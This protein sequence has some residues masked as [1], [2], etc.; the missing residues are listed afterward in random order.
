MIGDRIIIKEEHI[1]KAS[2]IL[3][4]ITSLVK[5]NRKKPIK[6]VIGIGGESG[7]GKTEINTVIQRLLWE[8]HKLRAKQIHLDDYYITNWQNR[9][10]IRKEKGLDSI[11]ICEIQWDKLKQ[12]I[13][14]FKSHKKKLYVQRIHMFTDS[15]EYVI[16]NNRNIDILLIEGLYTLYLCKF[17]LIDLPIYLEGSMK[18]TY[19]FRKERYKENPDDTFRKLVLIR[20]SKEV[21]KTKK[22][23]KVVI[24]WDIKE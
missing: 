14:R 12:V 16:A 2:I 9:N 21:R 4:Y 13:K 6:I 19:Q 10:K 15:I 7:T 22:Y 1:K 8:K 5:N 23:A 3:P 20:E 24:L 18:D 17:G 11:G